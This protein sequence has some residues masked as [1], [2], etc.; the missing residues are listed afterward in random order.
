MNVQLK[1]ISKRTDAD[2]AHSVQNVLLWTTLLS[3]DSINVMVEGGWVTLSGEV[4]HAYQRTAAVAAVR[5]LFGVNGVS[6]QISVKTTVAPKT[7]KADIEATLKRRAVADANKISVV[8]DGTEV[9]LTGTCHS[10]LERELVSDAAWN[11]PGVR[12]VV[13][14][15]TISY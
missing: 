15:I 6:N 10:W 3:K 11:T 4:E 8:V 1:G 2:I 14:N 9:T 5:Y 7:V 12:S 13:D